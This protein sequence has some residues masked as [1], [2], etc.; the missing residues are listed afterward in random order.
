MRGRQERDGNAGRGAYAL[1]DATATAERER[2]CGA[3]PGP[4]ADEFDVGDGR[5]HLED[6][7]RQE[8]RVDIRDAPSGRRA[9]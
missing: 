7:L 3:F 9:G 1:D 4:S 8:R 5:L 2:P 6:D